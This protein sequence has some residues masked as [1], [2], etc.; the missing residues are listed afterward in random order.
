MPAAQ[1]RGRDNGHRWGG[2]VRLLLGFSRAIDWLNERF[3]RL[4]SWCVLIACIVS[5]GNA[6]SRYTFSLSSNAWLEIQWYL[7]T[8]MFLLGAPYT[9][10]V[11]EHIRV[12]VIFGG[13]KPRTQA[14]ID[15]IGGILFLMPAALILTWLCWEY[16]AK[17]YEIGEMSGNAGGLPRWP[18]KL[19]VPIGFALLSL[20]GM[21]EIIKR[22]AVL[23]GRTELAPKYEK[24]LQ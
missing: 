6:L 17:S 5:A 23:S 13:L 8:A 24:P 18:V 2:C 7:F 12:D 20:Q 19:I 14:W 16:F 9:L 10:K 21:S 15:L 3:G 22:A 4:A 11:N 1:G